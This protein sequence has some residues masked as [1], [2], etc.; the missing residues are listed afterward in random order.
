M[1][2]AII[3]DIVGSLREGGRRNVKS[4]DFELFLPK[5]HVTDDSVMSLAVAEALLDAR[6]DYAN[7]EE[8][9]VA[10]MQTL[11]RRYP[12]AGYG[13]FFKNWIFNDD[14]KPYGSYGNGAAMRVSA[15]GWVGKSLEEVIEISGRITRVTH[16]HPDGIKGAEA[17]AVSVFMALHGSSIDEIREYV[18]AHYYPMD[19]TIDGIRD[20][21]RFFISCQESVPQSIMAFLESTSFEDA[22][23]NAISIGGDSDTIA[24]IAGGIAEAYYGVPE[25]LREQALTY[26]DAYQ[27]GILEE[28][29][30]LY[31]GK[32]ENPA[33]R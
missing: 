25:H 15:C 7:L 3:G 9:A 4:K 18:N 29:E 27:R 19:F 5:A 17:T 28:F 30:S 6:G 23:R 13:R 14:P 8:L 32:V 21:Y 24:A 22:I 11:G 26:L 10:S 33:H 12:H 1:I 31:P 2:G 16:D 20:T